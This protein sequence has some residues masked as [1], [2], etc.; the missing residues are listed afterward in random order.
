MTGPEASRTGP[1]AGGSTPMKTG[2]RLWDHPVTN[3][4]DGR[5]ATK[6]APRQLHLS[7][8]QRR[9]LRWVA[10][11]HRWC[12]LAL[13]LVAVASPAWGQ[14]VVVK[15][16]L[17]GFPNL[18]QRGLDLQRPR[19]EH[20]RPERH[21]PSRLLGARAATEGGDARRGAQ[22]R[23]LLDRRCVCPVMGGAH[24]LVGGSD[25]RML[26]HSGAAMRA[27]PDFASRGHS[28]DLH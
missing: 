22:C 8:F 10:L 28:L 25:L 9:Q 5:S 4:D 23:R 24:Q 16:V 21:P 19:E 12:V 3:C 1:I 7:Q 2:C 6:P 20:D 17:C 15:D 13:A 27:R 18:S 14:A 11:A 26:E